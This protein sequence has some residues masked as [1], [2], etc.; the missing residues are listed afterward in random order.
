MSVETWPHH[1][2][3]L[4][5]WEALPE[6][7]RYRFEAIEGVLIVAP[8]PVSLHQRAVTRLGY[9][10]DEQLPTELSALAEVE[11]LVAEHPLTIRVPDVIVA[12]AA[13]VDGNA[14]RFQAA[15]LTLA[16]EI[17]SEGSRRTDTV[18]KF[19]EYAEVGIEHYWIVDLDDP[20]SM[21]T[22][23]LIDGHYENFGEFSGQ[24]TL[25]LAGSPIS[26]DLA[27]LTSSRARRH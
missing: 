19:S 12:A 21:T 2:L 20:V 22:Y 18:T 26:L 23:R 25:D 13:L 5:D 16:V 14:A 4:E 15:D 1:L 7:T 3:S 10:L 24:A 6:D 11:V 9:L 27:A 8:R 17:L